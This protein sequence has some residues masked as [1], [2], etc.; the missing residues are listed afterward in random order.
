M[1]ESSQD[2]DPRLVSAL[3]DIAAGR[4]VRRGDHSLIDEHGTDHTATFIAALA[5]EGFQPTTIRDCRLEQGE[6]DPAWIIED[7]YARFGYVFW[8][9]FFDTRARKIFG[10]VHKDAKGDWDRI[11][12][13]RSRTTLY[14]N[15]AL[16]ERVDPDNPSHW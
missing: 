10:T 12:G 1:P 7:G 16:R 11:I 3:R 5:T 9:R 4:G 13:G 6:R 14:V 15:P 8:E 2:P